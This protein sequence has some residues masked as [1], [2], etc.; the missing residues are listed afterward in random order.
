M[1]ATTSALVAAA[2]IS[3][4]IS[5]FGQYKEGQ[6]ASAAYRYN[7]DIAEQE[8]DFIRQGAVL[9]EYRQRKRLQAVTGAQAARY[10]KSGVS[11]LTGTPLDVMTDSIANAELEISIDQWNAENMAR[12]KRSE[13][14]MLRRYGKSAM[15]MARTKM[16]GTLLTTA[17]D[18][19]FK[20]YSEKGKT[21]VGK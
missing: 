18:T 17:V 15:S 7:A 11:V 12:R 19:G 13:A 14:Q 5:A 21:K 1:P 8:A 6:E 4:G 9:N 10:A 2:L 3:G 20:L 16:A